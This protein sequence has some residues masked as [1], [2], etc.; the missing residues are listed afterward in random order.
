MKRGMDF[1]GTPRRKPR[2]QCHV[3]GISIPGIGSMR[4]SNIPKN[5]LEMSNLL[6]ILGKKAH[7]ILFYGFL[8]G[9]MSAQVDACALPPLSSPIDI[10]LK[11]SEK[12]VFLWAKSA[13]GDELK[14]ALNNTCN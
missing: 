13:W 8:S 9:A 4:L 3:E 5:V 10:Y 7:A 11:H 6:L 2:V 14:Q 1:F 12:N